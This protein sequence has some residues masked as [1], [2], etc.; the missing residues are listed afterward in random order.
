VL[1]SY[2][3][4]PSAVACPTTNHK[5]WRSAYGS[6]HRILLGYMPLCWLAF[7]ALPLKRL[8]SS[9]SALAR[10]RILKSEALKTPFFISKDGAAQFGPANYC[11]L[12]CQFPTAAAV[13]S[14]GYDGRVQKFMFVTSLVP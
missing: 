13:G 1:I 8:Q 14:Y 11:N 2:N 9:L 6:S 5:I 3:C 4:H 12:R 10:Q 7:E